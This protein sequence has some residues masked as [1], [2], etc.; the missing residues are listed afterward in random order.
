MSAAVAVFGLAIF[1]LLIGGIILYK[2][3]EDLA[4]KQA[5][6]IKSKGQP[7]P[8]VHAMQ[9]DDE[10]TFDEVTLSEPNNIL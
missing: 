9:P 4:K 10:D 2:R 6:P 5:H 1:A 7:T 3:Q 8:I